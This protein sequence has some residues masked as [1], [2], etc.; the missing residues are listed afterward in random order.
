MASTQVDDIDEQVEM[1][2][3]LVMADE[4]EYATARLVDLA[5]DFARSKVLNMEARE[6]KRQYTELLTMNR[7]NELT[8]EEYSVRRSK[9]THRIQDLAEAIKKDSSSPEMIEVSRTSMECAE[10]SRKRGIPRGSG[11]PDATGGR[12]GQP[13]GQVDRP[14]EA[15][16]TLP[17]GR[18]SWVEAR[19]A[20]ANQRAKARAEL[21]NGKHIGQKGWE[22]KAPEDV[23]FWCR[24][25]EKDYRLSSF[26]FHLGEL[27]FDL[28]PGEITGLVGANGSGKSTLL[29]IVAGE[30]AASRGRVDFPLLSP[31]RKDWVRIRMQTAYM[32]QQPSRWFGRLVEGLVLSAALHGV[33]SDDITEEVEYVLE[34]L[35]LNQYRDD[36]W[37]QLSGGFQMRFE[38]ARCLVWNPRLLIMDEPLAPLDIVTQQRFLRDLKDIATR[39]RRSLAVIVSSQHLHEIESVSDRIIFLDGGRPRFYGAIEDIGR[40][41][42]ENC[43]ELGCGLSIGDL[44]EVLKKVATH[45]VEHTGLDFIIR[46]PTA[47][48]GGDLIRHLLDRGIEV[49]YFRDISRSSKVMLRDEQIFDGKS[50]AIDELPASD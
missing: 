40:D 37:D 39:T 50:R 38:L 15:H 14:Q 21:D 4:L 33:P 28:A 44:R 27:S 30:V 36:N 31:G 20:F 5:H 43:F 29:E 45:S 24:G 12:I 35:G 1:L 22:K 23:I 48:A 16:V 3:R 2:H 8:T 17:L 42:T 34:R 19:Q 32:P 18:T 25:I 49:E 41:R 10:S 13:P 47:T 46:T 7:R 11:G 6:H 9:L 26:R